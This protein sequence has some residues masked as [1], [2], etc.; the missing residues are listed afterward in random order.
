MI[1]SS[2]STQP[3]HRAGALLTAAARPATTPKTMKPATTGKK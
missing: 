3:I 1:P 2:A